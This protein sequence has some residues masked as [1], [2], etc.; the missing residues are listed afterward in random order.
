MCRSCWEVSS[1]R[2]ASS[3]YF[4][5]GGG[6]VSITPLAGVVGIVSM[7]PCPVLL[8]P[9]VREGGG[10]SG[11][12][13]LW[14]ALEPKA[15]ALS[16]RGRLVISFKLRRK[17]SMTSLAHAPKCNV[18]S[19]P[20]ACPFAVNSQSTRV[21]PDYMRRYN[22]TTMELIPSVSHLVPSMPAR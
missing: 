9:R 18:A 10:I 13:V 4:E 8:R 2:T 22:S 14:S 20:I 1:L 17:I 3:G 16:P 12:P 19:V 15:S 11:R 7:V 6:M 5:G 21:A